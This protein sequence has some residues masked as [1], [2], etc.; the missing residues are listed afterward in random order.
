MLHAGID[1]NARMGQPEGLPADCTLLHIAANRQDKKVA[2]YLLHHGAHVNA[3]DSFGR[4]PLF[5]AHRAGNRD[6]VKL[7]V[8]SGARVSPEKEVTSTTVS[9][10][11]QRT[12]P[13]LNDEL[14]TPEPKVT[15]FC[16]LPLQQQH[17]HH[18][19]HHHRQQ[20][21]RHQNNGHIT[22]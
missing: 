13:S 5:Y 17:H 16:F 22:S 2:D 7:L 8:D 14:T 11:G 18:H 3:R 10:P 4:T 12:L 15:R 6:V 20:H 9:G 19:H 21:H 1:V